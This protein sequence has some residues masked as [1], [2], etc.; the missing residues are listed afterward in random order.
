V[1]S[2][3]LDAKGDE[4][5]GPPQEATEELISATREATESL[6]F[7]TRFFIESVSSF[8]NDFGQQITRIRMDA[9]IRLDL[10]Y[11]SNEQVPG[12]TTSGPAA[13]EVLSIAS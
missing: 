13:P 12:A 10:A 11:T 4:V 2:S 5:D 7:S 6:S 1:C 3:D 8:N 9:A